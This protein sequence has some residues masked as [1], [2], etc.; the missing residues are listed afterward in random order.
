MLAKSKACNGIGLDGV[1]PRI[2]ADCL[3]DVIQENIIR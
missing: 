1:W 3:D 2:L